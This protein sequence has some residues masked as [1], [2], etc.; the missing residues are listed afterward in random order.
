MK[1]LLATW[2]FV[3]VI[4]LGFGSSRAT[5]AEHMDTLFVFLS[6]DCPISIA[7]LPHLVELQQGFPNVHFMAISSNNMHTQNELADFVKRY[8]IP[9]PLHND[10]AGMYAQRFGISITPECAIVHDATFVY[11]GRLNNLYVALGKRRRVVTEFD[12]KRVLEQLQQ[13]IVP[14]IRYTQAIGCVLE[15]TH[16]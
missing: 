13:G 2:T 9:F 8:R 3:L 1:R 10:T 15:P 7:M 6:I 12:A 16:K 5:C 4:V 14:P 11:R